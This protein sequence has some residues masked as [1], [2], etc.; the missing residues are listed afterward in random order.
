MKGLL[1]KDFKLLK[2][3]KG[4]FILTFIL[5]L[6]F[7][8]VGNNFA[9]SLNFIMTTIPVFTINTISYDEFDN[10]NAF[11]FS[12]PFSRKMFVFEKYILALILT[13]ASMLLGFASCFIL[14][15]LDSTPFFKNMIILA[16]RNLL[17]VIFM[18][19]IGMP[20]QFISNKKN[21]Q[22]VLVIFIIFL[23]TMGVIMVRILSLYNITL[24]NLSILDLGIVVMIIMLCLLMSIKISISI[25]NKKDF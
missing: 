18:L 16:F 5:A 17:I 8:I 23:L 4:F 13:I 6:G 7:A 3:K 22:I 15:F 24:N 12:L 1:I 21:S 14:C 9:Y 11:M 25:L 2:A 10:S 20:F 19:S